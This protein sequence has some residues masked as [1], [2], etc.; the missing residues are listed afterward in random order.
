MNRG[1]IVKRGFNKL[2]KADSRNDQPEDKEWGLFF[3]TLV[4]IA[5]VI[6]WGLLN[7]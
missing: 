3:V 1:E 5:V 4:I 6:A 2:N 7:K